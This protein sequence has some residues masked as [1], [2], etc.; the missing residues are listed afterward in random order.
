MLSP[1]RVSIWAEYQVRECRSKVP[2]LDLLRLDIY[3]RLQ[4]TQVILIR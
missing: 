2:N 3:L 1:K 4:E